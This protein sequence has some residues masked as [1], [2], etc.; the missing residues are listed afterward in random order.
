M[1]SNGEPCDGSLSVAMAGSPRPFAK[2]G[3]CCARCWR[4]GP[5]YSVPCGANGRARGPTGDRALFFPTLAKT[6][7]W[8]A[9]VRALLRRVVAV[10]S[11]A[12]RYLP[13]WRVGGGWAHF[14]EVH[15]LRPSTPGLAADQITDGGVSVQ[16][17]SN[18]TMDG[19]RS[20][21]TVT[22]RLHRLENGG[23]RLVIGPS[24]V[25]KIAH[26]SMQ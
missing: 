10:G 16:S 20:A 8:L 11:G 23:R 4:A 1:R 3:H 26:A 2:G 17:R 22:R 9:A 5:Y 14:R 21:G 13:L 18:S 7:R 12:I 24:F 6:S 25:A 15:V 19:A